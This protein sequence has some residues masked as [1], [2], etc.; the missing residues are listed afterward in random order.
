[1][2]N[3]TNSPLNLPPDPQ[4]TRR[5]VRLAWGLVVMGVACALLGGVIY[6]GSLILNWMDDRVATDTPESASVVDT[7]E[8]VIAV[9]PAMKP[10]FDQLVGTFSAGAAEPS[11][12]VRTVELTPEKMVLQSLETTPGFQALA[13]DSSLWLHQLEQ[14]WAVQVSD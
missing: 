14:Q 5:Q 10:T 8:L 2:A 13:P 4:K 9:S 1:M 11:L 7:G 12:P 6:G 3:T